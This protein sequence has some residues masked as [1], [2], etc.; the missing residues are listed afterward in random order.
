V[1][2]VAYRWSG[3]LLTQQ[4]VLLEELAYKSK[5]TST[6]ERG[7]EFFQLLRDYTVVGYYTSKIGPESLGYPGLPGCSHPNDPEHTHLA[8][9]NPTSAKTADTLRVANAARASE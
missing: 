7:R 3:V 8:E 9:P 4:T 2:K 6:T 5:Y 1:A